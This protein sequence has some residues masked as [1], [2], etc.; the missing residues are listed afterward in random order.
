MEAE[1]PLALCRD[2]ITLL[3][4]DEDVLRVCVRYHACTVHRA[5]HTDG[6]TDRQNA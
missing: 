3:S 2:L 5:E 1:R 6:R 4:E